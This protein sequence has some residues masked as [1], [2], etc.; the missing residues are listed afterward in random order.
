MHVSHSP[1]HHYLYLVPKLLHKNVIINAKLS[2]ATKLKAKAQLSTGK[3]ETETYLGIGAAGK[4]NF[5]SSKSG[6]NRWAS[7]R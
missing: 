7:W 4:P 3:K 6:A 5:S 2:F 1:S